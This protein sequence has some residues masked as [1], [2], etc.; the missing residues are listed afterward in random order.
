MVLKKAVKPV[1]MAVPEKIMHNFCKHKH[2]HASLL[3]RQLLEIKFRTI[4]FECAFIFR[5]DII[6]VL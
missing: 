1:D 4:E 5:S 6:E 3:L 2:V